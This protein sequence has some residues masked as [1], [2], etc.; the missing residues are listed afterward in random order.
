MS[1]R[2]G[3]GAAILGGGASLGAATYAFVVD[4]PAGVV[5]LGCVIAALAVA[6]YGVFAPRREAGRGSGSGPDPHRHRRG[7]DGGQRQ[8]LRPGAGHRGLRGGARRRPRRV[9]PGSLPAAGAESDP[10]GPLR[11]PAF[12]GRQGG[13]GRLGGEGS[14]A[15]HRDD[16]DGA[17]RRP[18]A[19]GARRGAAR[20]RRPGD[21]RR[22]R[23][24]G[25]G[26]GDRRRAR[27]CLRL[28]PVRDPQ[29]LCPRPRGGPRRRDRG[30]RG[31]HRRGGASGGPGR[32]QRARL[33]QQCLTR[34]LRRGGEP[35][36][37]LGIEA[38]DPAG[39]ADRPLGPGG[40]G[41]ELLAGCDGA[42][43]RSTAL[44]LVSNNP[45]RLG[46]SLGSGTR[47]RLDRG[48]LGVV[49]F[50]PPTAGRGPTSP[51]S[52]SWS[53]S[54][55]RSRPTGRSRP[56]STAS[57]CSSSRRCDSRSARAPSG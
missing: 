29:P 17:R 7:G 2:L 23:F 22:R 48:V 30:A 43:Q 35:S 8:R 13:A 27:A 38:S 42:E 53:S 26:R 19:A 4:F 41:A 55:W 25:S 40:G 46:T 47:P 54:S 36:R 31:V 10:P 16:R 45:Y 37:K 14:R 15:R 6:W 39:D 52:A 24:P 51:A 56:A 44:V 1:R 34:R 21:G 32:G 28:H 20:S 50:R 18:R 11:Q 5:V 57:R 33:R 9:P 3:A 12:G 49:D